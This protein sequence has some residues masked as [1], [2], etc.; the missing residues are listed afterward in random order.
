MK[1]ESPSLLITWLGRGEV[2]FVRNVK[3]TCVTG[4]N[5][6]QSQRS[7]GTLTRGGQNSD[8]PPKE[9]QKGTSEHKWHQLAR[10]PQGSPGTLP[11]SDKTSAPPPRGPSTRTCL[12]TPRWP[13][14][15]EAQVG[16]QGDD[17]EPDPQPA[18]PPVSCS[19]PR[20]QA[21]NLSSSSGGQGL[22]ASQGAGT[23]QCSARWPRLRWSR[24]AERT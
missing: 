1:Q 8:K 18:G 22:A 9:T 3:G 11:D 15:P 24:P 10:P 13:S 12:F 6:A 14:H 23:R 21:A 16:A 2:P 5:G 4:T 20:A 7:P 19:A 17:P